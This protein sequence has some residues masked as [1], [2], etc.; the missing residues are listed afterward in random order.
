MKEMNKITRL[1]YNVEITCTPSSSDDKGLTMKEFR[2][3]LVYRQEE[4]VDKTTVTLF[5]LGIKPVDI[6]TELRTFFN[7]KNEELYIAISIRGR[8]LSSNLYDFEFINEQVVKTLSKE[9]S[10][11]PGELSI[12][13]DLSKIN[14]LTYWVELTKLCYKYFTHVILKKFLKS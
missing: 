2:D 3:L 11:R 12:I 4:V 10:F 14:L 1:M 7:N 13:I 9:F 6:V 8:G 5:Y